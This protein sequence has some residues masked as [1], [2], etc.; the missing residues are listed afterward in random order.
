MSKRTILSKQKSDV[1]RKAHQDKNPDS[2][3]DQN[4]SYVVS[5]PAK[6]LRVKLTPLSTR[7]AS[8]EDDEEYPASKKHHTSKN[9]SSIK[10]RKSV[11]MLQ[12]EP[13]L[14][15]KVHAHLK[16]LTFYEGNDTA[17]HVAFIVE[18]V[19]LHVFAASFY[20]D[21]LRD[22]LTLATLTF[23][24]GKDATE[25]YKGAFSFCVRHELLM[26]GPNGDLTHFVHRNPSYA[27]V[28][29]S[30]GGNMAAP[31]ELVEIGP[32][33]H[34]EFSLP[35]RDVSFTKFSKK[36][37]VTFGEYAP[38]YNVVVP[39]TG[40]KVTLDTVV[41]L[42]DFDL[43]NKHNMMD[44]YIEAGIGPRM[45][46]DKETP[47]DKT[48][49]VS[50]MEK[51]NTNILLCRHSHL[52]REV[53]RACIDGDI[54]LVLLYKTAVML[55]QEVIVNSIIEHGH[56]FRLDLLPTPRLNQI[57]GMPIDS[58]FVSGVNF[59]TSLLYKV[60]KSKEV[61]VPGLSKSLQIG[62]I[63]LEFDFERLVERTMALNMIELNK[64]KEMIAALYLAECVLHM[65]PAEIGDVMKY[66]P[67][68]VFY[69]S[70]GID[71]FIRTSED[72]ESLAEGLDPYTEKDVRQYVSE[73]AQ[74]RLN[75]ITK[76]GLVYPADEV[77]DVTAYALY[78]KESIVDLLNKPKEELTTD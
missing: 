54:N 21:R 77:E 63:S 29:A 19:S 4:D 25:R 27:E 26:Y 11:D 22:T 1:A 12:H 28:F 16:T 9:Y 7:H 66:S 14:A 37:F 72:L 62:K 68:D 61:K 56:N 74:S 23:L 46:Y 17:T 67:I 73:A 10:R 15:D 30:F 51:C 42:R 76:Y 49:F 57:I 36:I 47:I 8:S 75:Y 39:I 60:E 3:Y 59:Y 2:K 13:T 50:I 45:L 5:R 6:K 78:P 44:V 41:H 32:R 18:N 40:K 55:E 24:N 70:E 71:L 35:S 48:L 65:P 43:V 33:L 20:E 58:T 52:P 69:Y 64:Q 38:Y 53:I 31:I 34:D